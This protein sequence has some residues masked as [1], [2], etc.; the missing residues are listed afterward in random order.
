[1]KP[2]RCKVDEETGFF[3]HILILCGV[4]GSAKAQMYIEWNC[5]TVFKMSARSE[6]EASLFCVPLA[7]SV[8]FFITNARILQL[9]SYVVY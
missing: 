8:V 7:F 3:F 6:V 5:Y 1:M 2:I 9:P 4:Q